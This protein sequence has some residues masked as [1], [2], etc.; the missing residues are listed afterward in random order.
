MTTS[1]D[2]KPK[3][4]WPKNERLYP[5]YFARRACSQTI[6]FAADPSNDKFPATVLTHASKSHAL[7]SS[8]GEIAAADAATLAPSSKTEKI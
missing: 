5:K 7:D 1:V 8:A 4:K 2:G 6:K 3:R